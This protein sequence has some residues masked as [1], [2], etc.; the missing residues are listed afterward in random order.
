MVSEFEP[1]KIR[2]RYSK[3][4]SLMFISHLDLNRTMTASF[5]RSRLPIYYSQGFNPHPKIVFSQPL[6]VGVSS[7]CEYMDFSVTEDIPFEKITETMNSV[8]PQGI[9]FLDCYEPIGKF[10]DIMWA[11]YEYVFDIEPSEELIEKIRS[12]LS[13]SVVVDKKTKSGVKTIDISPLMDVLSV[14]ENDGKTSVRLLLCCDELNFVGPNIP[15]KYLMDTVTELVDI[16]YTI[17][18]K[19]VLLSDKKTDFR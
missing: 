9:R 5:L 14:S 4:G 2:V 12:S 17:R 16:E 15:I 8:M 18:R 1:K 11:E 7:E 6:P 13:G 3:S 10:K 19:R